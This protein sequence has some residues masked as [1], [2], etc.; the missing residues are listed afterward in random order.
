MT[1]YPT[2]L[3]PFYV[4]VANSGNTIPSLKNSKRP[5][6]STRKDGSQ[7]V[8]IAKSPDVIRFLQQAASVV[9][10]AYKQQE[11]ETIPI[12]MGVYVYCVFSVRANSLSD[13]D[14]QYTTI[15]E[16]LQKPY[17]SVIY[18]DR[19]VKGYAVDTQTIVLKDAQC[20]DI[21]V[22][23][24]DKL[25]IVS[26]TLLMKSNFNDIREQQDLQIDSNKLDLTRF[27]DN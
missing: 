6:I 11:F 26:S 22:W 10:K 5:I 23:L 2:T 24:D 17:S 18:N 15:Q 4:R 9:D 14:N 13:I 16:L 25:G 19:Q 3:N 21:Y 27:V 12:S 1:N 7:Y 20:V 8:A